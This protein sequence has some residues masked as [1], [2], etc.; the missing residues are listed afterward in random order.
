MLLNLEVSS[1]YVDLALSLAEPPL[2][3]SRCSVEDSRKRVA[4]VRARLVFD[5]WR[6]GYERR[7]ELGR[8]ESWAPHLQSLRKKARIRSPSLTLLGAW[9]RP[10]GEHLEPIAGA[11]EALAAL[12]DQGLQLALVSNV[13]LPGKLYSA[14]LKRHGLL[15]HFSSLQFSY[16][17]GSRKPSPAMLRSALTDLALSPTEAV[18]VGDRRDSDV[19]AGRA[20]G[21]ATVW[22]RSDGGGGPA[23]DYTIDALAELPALLGRWTVD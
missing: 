10:Y 12:A 8:E 14:V 9:F 16:D 15:E 20:A 6:H 22:V 1:P 2:G 4:N 11:S 19:A 7:R 5:P 21:T 17:T 13:P 18:M 3:T 23:A